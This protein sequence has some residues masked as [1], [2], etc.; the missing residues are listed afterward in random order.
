MVQRPGALGV[1][2][3]VEVGI[4]FVQQLLSP[5]VV[6]PQQPVRLVE[7]VFPQQGRSEGLGG[8]EEPVVG[9]RH[10]GRVEHPLEL[11]LVIEGLGK[12]E[13]VPVALRRGAD[14]HL[15]GLPRRGEAGGVAEPG[16]LPPAGLNAI[17]DL[18]HGGQDGGL[19]LVGRQAAQALLAGQLDVDGQAVGQQAQPPGEEGVGPR[20]GLGV[21]I[22]AEAVLLPQQAQGLDH[23]LGGAVGAAPHGGGEEESLD[24][25]APV[26]ADGELRQLPWGEGGPAHIAGAAVDAVG[27]VVDAPV[28]KQHLEQGDAPA[29]GGEGV[30]ASGGQGAPQA[31]GPARPIQPAGGARR[32]VLGRVGQDGQLV[33]QLHTAAP[34][35]FSL[36]LL[37]IEH[38]FQSRGG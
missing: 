5:E 29:V 9:H 37:Y 21:D 27:A 36:A 26:K 13:D 19:G 18:G 10:I 30:A 8:G 15:G 25:V 23:G 33:Q 3:G 16:Q 6:E 22:A 14:N 11:V 17:P 31:A 1:Y 2:Q 38:L 28:G 32:V 24:V 7:P 12:G 4:G 35:P 34:F 20:D